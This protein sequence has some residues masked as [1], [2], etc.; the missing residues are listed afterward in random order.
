MHDSIT[1]EEIVTKPLHMVA[2][3]GRRRSNRAR[4]TNRWMEDSVW[5]NHCGV[6]LTLTICLSL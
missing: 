1:K 5:Q 2:K 3:N 4:V 6:I